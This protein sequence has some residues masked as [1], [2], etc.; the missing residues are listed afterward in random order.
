M[1]IDATIRGM[2]AA[3]KRDLEAV[4]AT[5]GGGLRID[6]RVTDEGEAVPAQ[7]PMRKLFDKGLIQGKAGGYSRVVHTADGLAVHRAIATQTGE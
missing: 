1:D 2:T 6:C 5:N 4:C 3:Q 7:G